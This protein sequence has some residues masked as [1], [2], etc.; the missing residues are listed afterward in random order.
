MAG[1]EEM[2]DV[3]MAHAIAP[4]AAIRISP[5]AVPRTD[6]SLSRISEYL[7]SLVR[8]ALQS[9]P[10]SGVITVTESISDVCPTISQYYELDRLLRVA[11]ARGITVVASSGDS[12]PS[13]PDCGDTVDGRWLYAAPGAGLPAADPLVT[14]VG[15]TRL[16]IGPSGQ[17]LGERAWQQSFVGSGAWSDW[18]GSFASGGGYSVYP[19]PPYQRGRIGGDGARGVPDVAADADSTTGIV[20]TYVRNGRAGYMPAAGT[21]ASAPLWAGIVALADQAAHRKL[22]FINTGL[23]RIAESPHYHEAFHDVVAG[24]NTIRFRTGWPARAG[25]RARPGWDAVTGWGTPRAA[26]LAALLK[27]YVH[28]GDAQQVYQPST[29]PRR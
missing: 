26:G 2:M 25:Y 12:G 4:G 8:H 18:P 19:A 10:Q 3:E 14:G 23:Y 16:R 5:V 15:G 1:P 9:S 24:N 20:T 27:Q 22:G 6:L 7:I 13:T 17:Y 21:S 29:S 11:A 28:P